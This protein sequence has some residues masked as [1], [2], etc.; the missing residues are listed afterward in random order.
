MC[1]LGSLLL[2]VPPNSPAGQSG[3]IVGL[4]HIPVAVRDLEKA[5]AAYR[6]LGFAIK[7]GRYHT[8]GIRN[9][10]VKFRGGS[11]IEPLTA[12]E[13][14]DELTK[15]YLELLA[16]GEGPAFLALHARDT[17]RLATELRL[18][19]YAFSRDGDV[20][21]IQQP[22][23]NYLFVVSD[24]R[25]PTDRPEHFAHQNGVTALRKE[26]RSSSGSWCGLVGRA[27]AER[28]RPL[29]RRRLRW[30]RSIMVKS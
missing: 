18:G 9:A 12:G 21:N 4:D 25:S 27:S 29:T 15:R 2:V 13:A 26:E 28:F 5:S 19:G 23:L 30:S 20:I 17:G 7:P 1:C 10:H 3:P 14:V 11:G 24:N 22:A 8:N 16:I 6:A